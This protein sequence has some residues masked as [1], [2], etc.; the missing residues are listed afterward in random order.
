MAR[1]RSRRVRDRRKPIGKDVVGFVL[2]VVGI[3]AV[4]AGFYA[5]RTAEQERGE[6]N[7]Q[8]LCPVSGPTS[9]D[10][11]LIDKTDPLNERQR[12]F[13]VNRLQE[14]KQ[15][16]PS[17]GAIELF[18]ISAKRDDVLKPILTLCNP[19]RGADA[20][21]ITAS[22]KRVEA[23]WETQFDTPLEAELR[24]A[25]QPSAADLSPVM[26]A[27]QS[28]SIRTLNHREVSSRPRSLTI[29]SDLLHNTPEFSQYQGITNFARFKGTPYFG[30]VRT[31]LDGVAVTVLYVPRPGQESIQGG[32]H[33]QFWT[34][35]FVNQG[36][37]DVHFIRVEG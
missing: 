33:V 5:Y 17:R 20:N 16:V 25:V 6:I 14:I 23:L 11:V 30:R 21:P 28:V 32:A 3:G 34:E 35:Y 15:D 37:A 4:V 10:I 8:T 36:A 26:E 22:P 1:P 12:A 24:H 18:A 19:G 13:V 7:E 31:A 27:I 2:A 9:I 29:V